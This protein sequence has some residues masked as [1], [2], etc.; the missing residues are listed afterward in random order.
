MRI[1]RIALK[2]YRQF[3]NT[4][5]LFNNK[6]ESDL[7]IF[8][9]KNGTG[10]TNILNA[11]NWCLYRDEPHLSKDSH[12]LPILNLKCIEDAKDGEDKEI[13]VEIHTKTGE[14][15]YIMFRRRAVYR[16]Y[17]GEEQPIQQYTKFEVIANDEKGNTEIFEDEEANSYVERF[18][19]KAIRE[20]FFF[21]GERLDT[22]FRETTAQ[23]IRHAIFV[24]SQ[25][26]LLESRVEKRLNKILRELRKEA[27]KISPEIEETRK[28]LEEEEDKIGTIKER[29]EEYK[30]QIVI[31]K[32]VIGECNRKLRDVPDV[33]VLEDERLRLKTR[34][35]H[36]KKLLD[37]KVKV[38]QNLL[39]EYGINIIMWPAIEMSIEKISEKRKN[40]EIPPTI[41]KNL[42]NSILKNKVCSICGTPLDSKTEK[43]VTNLL[44]EIKL[45]SS[46]AQQLLSIENPLYLL[47]EKI[48]QFEEKIK[49]LTHEI[50]NYENELEDLEK[51]MGKIDKSLSGYNSE[52]IKEL[53][54]DLKKFQDVHDDSLQLLG[55]SKNKK[56]EIK[57]NIKIHKK[58]Y[59]EE[60]K[61]EEKAKILRKEIDFCGKSLN[62]VEK[63]KEDI[64]NE[65]REIIESETKK[66]FFKLIWK[67]E[68]FQDININDNYDINLIHSM[69]YDCLGSIGAAERELLALSFTLALHTISGFDSPILIDTPVARVSDEHRVN[70][71]NVFSEVSNIKQIILLFTPAEYSKDISKI[72][73]V[74]SSNRFLCKLL[75]DE[76]ETKLEVI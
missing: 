19:P 64:M 76:N 12:Q 40:K 35:K 2:N 1:E 67:K 23:N 17:K 7:H 38:K 5:V 3:K 62:V 16:V 49:G 41:N 21:D 46:V 42:L 56:N 55:K 63:T 75:P 43:N 48:K 18:V 65:N 66:L 33:S 59:D 20:F 30:K 50:I 71:G 22:Y 26:E 8:I 10:K 70:L 4:E 44:K 58:I 25:V 31:S 9:G 32:T 72:L 27:G 14:N 52:K 47:K 15:K 74:K 68:T 69:G 61:K 57:E 28:R 54:S 11:I 34:K 37:E 45:S 13:I 60:I 29:I 36:T 6:R 73:D 53:H 51:K 39:F 24:I